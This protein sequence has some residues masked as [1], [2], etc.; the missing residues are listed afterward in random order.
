MH[1]S[2]WFVAFM[3][4]A[5]LTGLGI[6]A[7]RFGSRGTRPRVW[8]FV[9]AGVLVY[10]FMLFLSSLVEGLFVHPVF[11]FAFFT[12]LG[13]AGLLSGLIVL[14]QGRHLWDARREEEERRMFAQDL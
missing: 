13:L 11:E 10:S 5:M 14:S 7:A 1:P 4:G 3:V 6:A 2:M 9:Y 12:P 8:T